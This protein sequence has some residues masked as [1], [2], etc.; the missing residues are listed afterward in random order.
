MVW[1]CA[2]FL[3]G[4]VYV[5]YREAGWYA[6]LIYAFAAV[7]PALCVWLTPSAVYVCFM[8]AALG[9]CFDAAV[10]RKMLDGDIDIN[11]QNAS[12]DDSDDGAEQ[13]T[14]AA[15]RA[16]AARAE[17][18]ELPDEWDCEVDATLHEGAVDLAAAPTNITGVAPVLNRPYLVRNKRPIFV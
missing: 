6:I 17:T 14:V 18:V 3:V 9:E 11:V 2:T 4:I 13:A 8:C 15:D 5:V 7:P 16:A 1:Y 10:V 12:D